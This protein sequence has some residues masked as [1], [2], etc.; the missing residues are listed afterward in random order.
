[1]RND[2]LRVVEDADIIQARE[3][4]AIKCILIETENDPVLYR[5]VVDRLRQAN[6]GRYQNWSDCHLSRQFYHWTATAADEERPCLEFFLTVHAA[7]KFLSHLSTDKFGQE[8]RKRQLLRWAVEQILPQP[9]ESEAE[10]PGPIKKE[11]RNDKQSLAR[12]AATP[13]SQES[14]EK[15]LPSV[16]QYSQRPGQKSATSRSF[17]A[18]PRPASPF[19]SGSSF[20]RQAAS[21]FEEEDDASRPYKVVKTHHEPR[22][23][24]IPTTDAATQTT[25]EY[26]PDMVSKVVDTIKQAFGDALGQ[27]TRSLTDFLPTAVRQAFRQDVADEVTRQQPVDVVQPR[28]MRPMEPEMALARPTYPT[29]VSPVRAQPQVYDVVDY[30]Y[31]VRQYEDVRTIGGR[32][33]GR[34]VTT[35]MAAD[36]DRLV[37]LEAY[38]IAR[39]Q[40]QRRL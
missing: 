15:P 22:R 34:G 1:M 14:C 36:L 3:A 35:I 16:E 26:T 28:V 10:T 31:D 23:A 2:L 21:D 6:I 18:T 9:S 29:Y 33:G 32:G 12:T 27:Q 19:L 24:K 7:H 17:Q 25:A 4:A 30:P 13:S 37:G 11:K 39:G 38:R 20:K 5:C 8:V 40:E